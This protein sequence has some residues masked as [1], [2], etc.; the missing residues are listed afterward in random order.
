MEEAYDR[1][2]RAELWCCMREVRVPEVYVRVVQD[3]YMD[4]QIQLDVRWVL[5]KASQLK[6]DLH[7]GSALSPFLFAI[8]VDR[9][10]DGLRKRAPCSMMF[11][12]Y[13]VLYSEDRGEVE[14]DLEIWR[15]ALER[16]GMRVRRSNT[17]HLCVNEMEGDN[18]VCMEDNEL[19]VTEFK[20]FGTTIGSE[21]GS[22]TKIKKKYKHWIDWA[23][24]SDRSSV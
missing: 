10:T 14:E 18:R 2:P 17:E 11:A 3:M 4:C 16:H 1:V 6:W 9:L 22:T 5:P 23:K 20:Y 19:K 24:E 12:N 15:L 7:Q 21:G 13:V 8:I